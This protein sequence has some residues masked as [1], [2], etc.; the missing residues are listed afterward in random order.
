L[1][2]ETA[3]RK[4]IQRALQRR[5]SELAEILENAVEGVQQV[6][7]DQKILWANK[8]MLNLLGYSA[9]EYVNRPLA[10]FYVRK[11]VFDEFWTKL[12][13]GEEIYDYLAEL[14][15]KDG[16]VKQVRIHSNG[17]WEDGQFVHTR[18]FVR[19]VTEQKRMEQALRRSEA[20]L[21]LAT[22]ELES[23]VERRTVALRQ[24][25]SRLL[26]LQDSERRRIARELHDS[27]GQSLVAL[28]LNIEM[29]RRF[30]ARQELWPQSQALV[31]HCIS[32]VRTL[33]YLL[34]PPTM[35]AAGLASAARWYV[36]GF[37]QRSGLK[38]TV[39]VPDNLPRLPDAIELAL[40]R[41]LQEALTNV[42]RHS[43][44]SMAKVSIRQ[45]PEKVVLQVR[46]NGRGIAPELLACFR[47][48]RAGLGVGITSMGERVRELGGKLQLASTRRGTSVR[49]TIPL[50][51]GLGGVE[52]GHA[53]G[54]MSTD[55]EPSGQRE[56]M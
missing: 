32:E 38:L 4:K 13:R 49:I 55:Y 27:M 34:H 3:E 53:A 31:E 40:F 35:D 36:E 26:H 5:E 52:E 37:S 54:L 33:S 44:A 41:V 46:D 11:E 14:K 12:M 16:S 2:I 23:L 7:S 42:H 45:S 15:C 39:E 10:T 28:K 22:A 50:P 18:C 25:S 20:R 19:D 17:L 24:L 48:T 43:G 51:S 6:G 56:Q 29:L 21:R 30:P 47:K 1:S 8:A 9:R